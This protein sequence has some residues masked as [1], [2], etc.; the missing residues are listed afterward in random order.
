MRNIALGENH[1]SPHRLLLEMHHFYQ[2]TPIPGS[3][4]PA[5]N[6]VDRS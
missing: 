4:F 2:V 3:G 6:Q 1:G 5:G